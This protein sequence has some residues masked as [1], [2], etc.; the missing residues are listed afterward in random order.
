MQKVG[1]Q[2]AAAFKELYAATASRLLGVAMRIVRRREVAEDA[3][4]DAFVRVWWHASRFDPARG[5]ALAWMITIVRNSAINHIRKTARETALETEVDGEADSL[6]DRMAE[7][8]GIPAADRIGLA[9]CLQELEAGPR[10][11]VVMAFADGWSHEE[12]AERL[13]HPLGTVKSWIRRSLLRLRE[14]LSA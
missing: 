3:L 2:D 8:P 9:R 7:V 5:P 10:Q 4:H 11:C 1:Q 13:G 6:L 12:L 14:C